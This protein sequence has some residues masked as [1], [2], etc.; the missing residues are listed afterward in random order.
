MEAIFNTSP[1]YF[2]IAGVSTLL[3]IIL[4]VLSAFGIDSDGADTDG[5]D[6]EADS[7][8]SFMV[9]SFKTIVAGLMGFG[10]TGL[11][12]VNEFD[13]SKS[14]AIIPSVVVAFI[15]IIIMSKIF[16]SLNKLEQVYTFDINHTIGQVGKIY[17]PVTPEKPGQVIVTVDKRTYTFTAVSNKDSFKTHERVVVTAVE[18]EQT[19]IVNKVS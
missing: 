13:W 8:A 17:L 14:K 12:L 5:F 19:V 9:F 1:A 6:I 16:Q 15:I 4:I 3:F 11:S 10:W 18:N 2:V 7:D